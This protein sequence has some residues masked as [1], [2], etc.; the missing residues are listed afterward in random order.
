[1]I[2]SLALEKNLKSVLKWQ[3]M[4]PEL[5]VNLSS[6]AAGALPA[7]DHLNT[8]IGE[9]LYHEKWNVRHPLAIYNVSIS[10]VCKKVSACATRLEGL[11]RE[12]DTIEKFNR[13][14]KQT[15]ELIDY[16]ELSLYSAVEHVDDVKSIAL[17]F[18]RSEQVYN[19]S[20]QKKKLLKEM[21]VVRDRLAAITNAL[22]HFQAR[23]RLYVVQFKHVGRD[24]CLHGMFVESYDNGKIG[25]SPIIHNGIEKII[26]LPSFL[27]EVV[28]YI[29]QMSL[30]LKE[31]LNSTMP[32][33]ANE[34][35]LQN[36]DAFAKACIAVAR[37]PNYSFDGVHP[38]ERIKLVLHSDTDTDDLLVSDLYGSARS[39]WLKG[40]EHQ[41]GGDR[42]QYEGD[43][44]SRSFD[45][46]HPS[47][48]RLQH[49]D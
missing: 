44:V 20:P 48:I 18:Y 29:Y 35:A 46:I 7:L 3:S 38:F 6:T 40:T 32:V 9:R 33:K 21:K 23:I 45:F 49:W 17:C 34:N 43:G 5:H 4:K 27:W 26:S 11:V 8:L 25:P 41:I 42:L 14:G 15:E 37:L 10:R 28:I 19:K 24:M 36:N 22:K 1:M 12:A 47:Q 13:L 16:I 30:L 39:P 31:F 2:F